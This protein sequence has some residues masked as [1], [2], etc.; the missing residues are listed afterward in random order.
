[1]RKT[2]ITIAVG[3]LA[4]LVLVGEV[5]SRK[6][7]G[8]GAPPLYVSYDGMEYKLKPNQDIVRFGNRIAINNASMRTSSNI[9]DMPE[10]GKSRILIFG[11]SVLWG[12]SQIDQA[13]IATS[14]LSKKLSNKY[15]IFNVSAG[16]WGP[17]NWNEYIKENGL[18]NADKV[19][20]LMN[21]GDLTD[22]PN[23]LESMP[24][25]KRPT[26][27]P[28]SALWE[29]LTRYVTPR[30]QNFAKGIGPIKQDQTTTD[31]TIAIS[32]G[33]TILNQTIDLIEKSGAEL[34]AV[35]F[36]SRGEVINEL[37][38]GKHQITKDILKDMG[39]NTLQSLPYF[40]RC[41]NKPSDLFVDGIHPYTQE[42]QRCLALVLE[43]AI[44]T[45]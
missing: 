36:C 3:A 15:E 41:S 19:I 7:I 45:P 22:M 1:M 5:V 44:A 28:P 9:Q 39:V 29:L 21:S 34:S 24:N 2:T 12:G 40:K 23:R 6:M 14:L 37:P 13:Y 18:F 30:I 20:L 35:Q 11:D 33:S 27:N 25:L 32:K 8:L 38:Q 31:E 16:S 26:T 10:P 43:D 42:G 4:S 17:G